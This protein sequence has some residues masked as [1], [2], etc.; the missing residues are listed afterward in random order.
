MKK[1]KSLTSKI[2]KLLL[3]KGRGEFVFVD[4]LDID[5]SDNVRTALKRLTDQGFL[6][7]VDR[8]IYYFPKL[9]DKGIVLKPSS[10]QIVQ[11]VTTHAGAKYRENNQFVLNRLSLSDQV[12][13]RTLYLTDKL[14]KTIN[15]GKLQIRLVADPYR[16][17]FKLKGDNSKLVIYAILGVGEG[18]VTPELIDSLRARIALEKPRILAHNV[19][20]APEWVQKVF[21]E[22]NLV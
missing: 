4:D 22:N 14:N 17:A 11:A 2:K 8:G 15:F 7:R 20:L 21:Y 10:Q 16:N 5:T 19:K 13:M 9:S 3:K 6:L 12:P 18:N 1:Q